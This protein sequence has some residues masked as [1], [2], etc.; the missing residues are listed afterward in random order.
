MT[1][2]AK[3][4]GPVHHAG[5]RALLASTLFLAACSSSPDPASGGDAG[6]DSGPVVPAGPVYGAKCSSMSDGDTKAWEEIAVVRGKLGMGALD[7][8]DAITKAAFGHSSYIVQNG[9]ALT[10]TQTAGKPGFTGVNFWDRMKAAGFTGPGSAMF[11][12]VHSLSDPHG[13]I[14]GEGGWINTLYHRIPFVSYGAKGY[15]FGASTKASTIDFSSG[16]A[17][18]AA[19]A[20]ATW[21]VDGDTAIWTTFRCASEVPNPLPG[22]TFAGYPISLTASGALAITEHTVE[23]DAGALDHVLLMKG[24]DS[25]GL[26]PAD[27]VYLIPKAPLKAS[28]KYTVK[29]AGTSGGAA[30][31]KTWVFTTGT[32]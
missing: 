19:G 17:K 15:G 9:G 26:I 22:Q 31:S 24:K 6:T 16:G 2:L 1:A 27:Q 32:K 13:A 20:L 28:T 11:E 10:H 4:R 18:P 8:N 29:I 7:C 25:T 5:M 3:P 23:G 12:V 21:P 30:F 14:L